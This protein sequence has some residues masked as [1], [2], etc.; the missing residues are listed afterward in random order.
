M[1]GYFMAISVGYYCYSYYVGS[2][3]IEHGVIEPGTGKKL[4]IKMIVAATQG[5]IMGMMSLSQLMPI[6][7][8]ITR[9]LMSAQEIFDVI[10]REPEIKNQESG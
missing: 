8:G 9:A 3:F 7:P 2:K 5:S 6:L 1:S 4:T 10:E